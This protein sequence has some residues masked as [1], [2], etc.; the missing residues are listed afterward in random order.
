MRRLHIPHDGH[1]ASIFQHAW[2]RFLNA[3]YALQLD[4]RDHQC[5]TEL[6]KIWNTL[7]KIDEKISSDYLF[8]ALQIHNQKCTHLCR[9]WDKL[10][11]LLDPIL[12]HLSIPWPM[13]L[14]FSS[15][16][17][18]FANIGRLGSLP[19]LHTSTIFL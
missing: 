10:S 13:P 11:E 6:H 15:S 4:L 12:N 14:I 19:R 5:Y 18:S 2:L 3:A 17:P 16:G 7:S 8:E 1:I 9:I